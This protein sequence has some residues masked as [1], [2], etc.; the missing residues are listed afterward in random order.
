MSKYGAIKTT[1]DGIK[2]D[3]KAES[4][5]Y[6]T[7][8]CLQNAGKIKDLTLQ[9]RFDFKLNNK[10]MFYYKADFSYFDFERNKTVIEDVKSDFTEKMKMFRL[11]KKIIEAVHGIEIE[12]VKL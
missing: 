9:P 2:F 6:L 7:L 3:S 11:K 10:L 4:Y 12:I 8:K 5:H 1:V